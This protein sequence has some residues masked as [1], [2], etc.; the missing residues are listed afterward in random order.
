[1]GRRDGEFVANNLASISF[2]L[3]W[4]VRSGQ[5]GRLSLGGSFFQSRSS[6]VLGA[7]CSEPGSP[8]GDG[9]A[10]SHSAP[11]EPWSFSFSHHKS[12]QNLVADCYALHVDQ[13]PATG[14]GELLSPSEPVGR[15][16]SGSGA[17][18]QCPECHRFA[19]IVHHDP[20]TCP[21][22]FRCR[23]GWRALVD[24]LFCPGGA[25]W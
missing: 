23:C 4:S 19:V 5:G 12:L 15:P 16:H 7:R 18:P 20:A 8:A 2:T 1:M 3:V 17:A 6:K 21:V 14:D 13:P 11:L 22:S 24:S 9:E 10:T 25:A